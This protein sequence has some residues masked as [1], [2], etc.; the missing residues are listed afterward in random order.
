[1]RRRPFTLAAVALSVVAMLAMATGATAG[2]KTDRATGGGQVIVG[3]QHAGETIAFTAQGT[4]TSARGQVQLIDRDLGT[5]QDQVRFHGVV[6][7]LLVMGGNTAIISGHERGT[8]TNPFAL[9][10]VDNGQG[11]GAGNDMIFFDRMADDNVCEQ[12]DD[13]DDD[14]DTALARGNAQVYEA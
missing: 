13:D 12:D 4:A 7:C 3:T 8:T 10:V 11:A 14:G 2:S 9:R 1:M 5:G 6:S